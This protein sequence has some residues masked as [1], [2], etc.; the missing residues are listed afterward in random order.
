[1]VFGVLDFLVYVMEFCLG[2]EKRVVLKGRQDCGR[3]CVFL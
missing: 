3:Y 2:L 1:M